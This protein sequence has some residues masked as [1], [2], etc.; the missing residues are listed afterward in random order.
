[1]KCF[2][3]AVL[4]KAKDLI[5]DEN[6]SIIKA[7]ANSLSSILSFNIGKETLGCSIVYYYRRLFLIL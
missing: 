6:P 2:V 7:A 3:Y 5:F 1:L 4:L